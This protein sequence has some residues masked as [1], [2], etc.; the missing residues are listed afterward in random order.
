MAVDPTGAQI[1]AL[2]KSTHAGPVQMINLLQFAPDGGRAGYGRYAE[3]VQPHLERVGARVVAMSE[4][5]LLV[6]GDDERPWW[7]A[8][9]TVE[10]PSIAAFLQMVGDP[11]YQAITHLRTTAL[12]RAEL[13]A[14]APSAL[15]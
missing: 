8:I 1:S 2:A 15:G 5:E 7:D 11:G 3:A 9:L 13:V 4:V 10:Y 6:I 12:T 14:T